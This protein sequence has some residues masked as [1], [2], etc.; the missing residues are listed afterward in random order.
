MKVITLPENFACCRVDLC[1]QATDNDEEEEDDEDGDNDYEQLP[2]SQLH[3]GP[4]A[5]NR[6]R[7]RCLSLQRWHVRGRQRFVIVVCEQVQAWQVLH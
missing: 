5:S 7:T 3:Q 4:G 2:S 6:H 1:N